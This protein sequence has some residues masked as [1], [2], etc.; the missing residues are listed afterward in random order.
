M[1]WK[2]KVSVW[3]SLLLAVVGKSECRVRVIKGGGKSLG[4][5]AHALRHL[6]QPRMHWAPKDPKINAASLQVS[7]D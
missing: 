4:F 2:S 7:R 6:G 1:D 3:N 5:Q